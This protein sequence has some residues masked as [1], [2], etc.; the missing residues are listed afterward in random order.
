MLTQLL[1]GGLVIGS[2]YALM[3]LAMSLTY[4][5]S[6][7]ANF[8]QGEMA[9]LST[10]A[11]FL[12]FQLWGWSF[13]V[14]FPLS[15]GLAFLLG[16]GLDL[17]LIRRVRQPNALSYLMLTLGVQLLIFGLAGWKFGAESHKLRLPISESRVLLE[18]GGT[19]LT[20]LDLLSLLLALSLMGGLYL[21]IH[22]SRWGLALQAS[23]QNPLAA[24]LSGIRVQR[25]RTLSF[26]IS[27]LTGA[28]AGLLIAPIT[29]LEPSMMWDPLLKGFAAA[30]LGGMKNLAGV[31]LGGFLLGLLE[32]MVG[33]YLSLEFK[34]VLAFLLIVLVLLFR[35]DGLFSKTLAAKA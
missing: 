3:G 10:Y 17:L 19:P 28:V 11:L 6:G 26:G 18:I 8:A 14:A 20:E 7:I 27:A 2:I 24:R 12:M 4:K 31:V 32:N 29:T 25:I 16:T 35:P 15:L 1:I 5:A 33:F 22:H 23:H 9:M 34:S 30:V 21:L 13:W